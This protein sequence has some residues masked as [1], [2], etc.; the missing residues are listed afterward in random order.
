MG[1]FLAKAWGQIRE[2]FKNMDRSARIRFGILAGS[3]VVVAIVAAALLGRVTYGVLYYNL[4]SAEAGAIVSALSERGV[5]YKTE[6]AGTILVPEEQVSELLMTLSA[7][8]VYDSGGDLNFS[9]LQSASGFGATDIERRAYLAFQYQ[10]NIRRAL[11]R[12]D[13][14][15]DAMVLITLPEESSFVFARD[16]RDA[17]AAVSIEIKNGAVLSPAEAVAIGDMVAKAAPGLQPENVSIVDSALNLY[18]AVPLAEGESGASSGDAAIVASQILLE[19]QVKQQLET[20]VINLLTP[21]FGQGRVKAGASVSLEFDRETSESV[22]FA[23]PVAGE[24]EGLVRSMERIYERTRDGEDTGGVPG[25]DSNGMG[26]TE[27]IDGT[28]EYPYLEL[29]EGESYA[30]LLETINYELNQTTTQIERARGT[31]KRLSIAVLVDSGVIE[32]DYT[33]EVRELVAKAVGVSEDSV[34]VQRLPITETDNMISDA[35]AAQTELLR[36]M[37]LR[38]LIKTLAICAAGLI[39]L[40]LLLFTARGMIR[41]GGK[42]RAALAAAGAGERAAADD[43]GGPAGYD[44]TPGYGD[45]AFDAYGNYDGMDGVSYVPGSAAPVGAYKGVTG[46]ELEDVASEESDVTIGGERPNT[47]T[48]LERMI[49]RD[50]KAVA[51]IL[52][53]WL[54]EE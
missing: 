41:S 16:A 6:G 39:A 25:T 20:S 40:G 32:E 9:I 10:D 37:K 33:A 29:G 5:P 21:V 51:Q 44:V 26:S 27:D 47:L 15:E 23:P 17:T 52:R 42:Q 46:S 22:E 4:P 34:A 48:Q 49:E 45:V 38:D 7:E 28:D 24:T 11:L 30:K 43:R 36:E 12:L 14:I 50:P 13:K 2:F 8:G 35:L 1:A 54:T 31:V 19:T 3:V 53:G 18:S